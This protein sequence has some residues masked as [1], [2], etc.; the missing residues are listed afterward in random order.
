MKAKPII[1]DLC[2]LA[3]YVAVVYGCALYAKPLG[4]VV[5]GTL[6]LTFALWCRRTDRS[7]DD[8]T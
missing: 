3:G 2:L 1:L 6:A 4:F 8:V 7:E 5:G